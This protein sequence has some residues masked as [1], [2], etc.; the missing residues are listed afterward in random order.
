[1]KLIPCTVFIAS[2]VLLSCKKDPPNGTIQYQGQNYKVPV[3]VSYDSDGDG[4]P[5]A[6]INVLGNSLNVTQT[7]DGKPLYQTAEDTSSPGSSS[8]SGSLVPTGEKLC[9]LDLQRNCDKNGGLYAYETSMNTNKTEMKT[10]S[11]QQQIDVDN[12]GVLDYINNIRDT[13]ISVLVA[14]NYAAAAAKA[15]LLIEEAA[16]RQISASFLQTTIQQA[17]ETSL[18]ESLYENNDF[19]DIASVEQKM[20]VAVAQAII[21]AVFEVGL[22]L[23]IDQTT[24][25]TIAFSVSTDLAKNIANQVSNQVSLAIISEYKQQLSSGNISTV[26]GLCPNGYH[27]PS[28]VEWMLFEMA[29]GMP[30]EDLTKYGEF[31][32][33][34]GAS[35]NVA[36]LMVEKHGFE[37][38]G[39]ASIN[40][41]FSQLD[42]AGVYW[43]STIG[44]DSKGDYVWVRQV[45]ASYT[46]V[47]R[48]KHY[49]KSGLSIRCFK[50]EK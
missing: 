22:Q 4:K 27:I 36:K 29:L 12:D 49:E 3:E 30:K 19:I 44:T 24:L 42:E 6:V 33:T 41:T 35:A 38:G 43:S 13:Q 28:D 18:L 1:M 7:P 50:D 32:T 37:Y 40:G 10:I 26:Q 16:G 14:N 47:V 9:Y 23:Y 17:I 45:D 8:G 39:Y 2:L 25:N 20:K 31:E 11:E 15:E 34:R 48:Y 21:D 5:D 46:G